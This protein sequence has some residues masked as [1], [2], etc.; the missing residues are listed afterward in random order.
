[1]SF[2]DDA[3]NPYTSIEVVELTLLCKDKARLDNY[4]SIRHLIRP[5]T[6]GGY[7]VAKQ[8]DRWETHATIYRTLREAVDAVMEAR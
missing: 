6:G 4:E 7:A 8:I 3:M 1:M 5:V 2:S